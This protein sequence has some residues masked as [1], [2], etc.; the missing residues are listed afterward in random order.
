MSNESKVN[1]LLSYFD[2]I[3]KE[4]FLGYQYR[5]VRHQ[6]YIGD[7]DV[8]TNLL[9]L[10]FSKPFEGRADLDY[11]KAA[12]IHKY[13]K[14]ESALELVH[15]N[16]EKEGIK[17]MYDYMHT[18][19]DEFSVYSILDYHKCLYSFSPFP[20]NAG[21][22]RN[23]DVYLPGTGTEL[24]EWRYIF[25][26]LRELKIETEEL[27]ELGINLK[28][29]LEPDDTYLNNLFDY[30]EKSVILKCKLIKVHP[31]IDG[32]GRT[33][34]C[35]LNKLFETAGIPPVYIREKER[36]EYHRAM[37]QAN[38]EGNYDEI[39]QFY[40]YKICDSIVE[41]DINEQLKEELKYGKVKKIL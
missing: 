36:T 2:L 14:N 23:N 6:L 25:R 19:E 9:K 7:D 3:T 18:T 32:N 24:T 13:I 10:Y 31:F 8:P 39:I 5:K 28:N 38:C 26:E 41:L 35:L 11:L 40:H 22:I 17:V 21:R 20:E 12:F 4:C 30:I 29:V 27:F 33:I 16:V 15:N 37:N 34:R 1:H